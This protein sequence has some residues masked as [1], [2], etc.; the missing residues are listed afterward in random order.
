MFTE[1]AA[2]M[3]GEG[4]AAQY[5]AHLRVV[6][7]LPSYAEIVAHAEHGQGAGA[8][9][10]CVC[11]DA[12]DLS[13]HR[14]GNTAV[15]AFEYLS[16]MGQGVPGVGAAAHG[17]A[18]AADRAASAVRSMAAQQQDSCLRR[19]T[20][21]TGGPNEVP[22]TCRTRCAIARRTAVHSGCLRHNHLSVTFCG[23]RVWIGRPN[24]GPVQS[25]V[26]V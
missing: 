7:E 22:L 11:H 2:G 12:D 6:D 26:V 14:R 9:R 5:V 19:R 17:Q 15:Q 13:Q 24:T 18:D 10:C 16:R 21:W 23:R 4:S 8:A 3:I 25:R 1:F 20:W